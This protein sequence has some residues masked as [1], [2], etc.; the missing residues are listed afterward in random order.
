MKQQMLLNL[1]GGTFTW[2][3][4]DHQ[5]GNEHYLSGIFRPEVGN[6]S[7]F[8]SKKMS[9]LGSAH[10]QSAIEDYREFRSLHPFDDGDSISLRV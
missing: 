5:V 8:P 3:A 9:E 7:S 2:S 6:E 1:A 4:Y 10:G